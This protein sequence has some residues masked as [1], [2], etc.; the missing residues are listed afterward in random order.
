MKKLRRYGLIGLFVI[1]LAGLLGIPALQPAAAQQRT[2]SLYVFPTQGAPGAEIYLKGYGLTADAAVDVTLYSL[3]PLQAFTVGT[4]TAG[5]DGEFTFTGV[6]PVM[7]AGPASIEAVYSGGSVSADFTVLPA[8][9]LSLG[10]ISG[11][12]GQTVSFSVDSLLPG[13]LRLDYDGAPI[14]GPVSVSDPIFNG[15]FIVPHDRPA[16]LG[17]RVNVEAVNLV[18]GRVVGRIRDGFQSQPAPG[19]GGYTFDRIDLPTQAVDPGQVFTI[20]G[21]FSPPPSFPLSNYQLKVLYKDPGGQILP[22]THGLAALLADGSFTVDAKMPSFF[23]GDAVAVSE[24]AQI[25]IALFAQDPT[26]SVIN[27]WVPGAGLIHVPTPPRFRIQVKDTQGHPI[28]N[29]VVQFN[30]NLPQMLANQP[31]GGQVSLNGSELKGG[32]NQVL[33]FGGGVLFNDE[34]DPYTCAAT[35]LYGK[36]DANGYFEPALNWDW[37][38]LAGSKILQGYLGQGSYYQVPLEITFSF[39]V[40]A[41]HQGFGEVDA[42]GHPVLREETILYKVTTN[43]YYNP[44]SSQVINA[45]DPYPVVL[46]ALPPA[47]SVGVPLKLSIPG[48]LVV[49]Y[50]DN[51]VGTG[52]PMIAYGKYV[53]FANTSEFPNAIIPG[54]LNLKVE[55]NNDPLLYGTL[56]LNTLTATLDGAL[57]NPGFYLSSQKGN[58]TGERYTLDLNAVHRWSV[59]SHTLLVQVKDLAGNISKH[60]LVIVMVP[61]PD[62]FRNA[63]LQDRLALFWG[64]GKVELRANYLSPS[65]PNTSSTLSANVP[66]IGVLNNMAGTNGSLNQIFLLSGAGDKQFKTILPYQALNNSGSKT[67]GA[68]ATAPVPITYSNT[69]PILDTGRVPLYRHVFGAP[70]IAGAVL[71]ADMWFKATLTYSGT[72]KIS[73]SAGTSDVHTAITPTAKVGVDA[74]VDASALFGL[75]DA[76]AHAIPNIGLSLPVEYQN[77]QKIDAKKCFQYKLDIS[78]S[79]SIGYCPLCVSA[80]GTENLFDGQTPSSC[81]LPAA[82]APLAPAVGPPPSSSPAIANDGAGHTLAVW[83]A[84]NGTILSSHNTGAGWETALVVS[85]NTSSGSP[86][87]AFYAPNRALAL[88]TQSAL[89]PAQAASATFAALVNSQRLAYAVWNGA[90]W[91]SAQLL[92]TGTATG[93]G[94]PALAACLSTTAGCPAGGAVAAAWV[95]DAA[96]DLSQHQYRIYTA[97]YAN[98]GWGTVQ[99]VDPASTAADAQPT[100]VYSG[101]SPVVLWVRD[102]DRDFGTL[103]DRRVAYRDLGGGGV[104]AP[105][106]LPYGVMEP[107]LAAD[108]SG[109]LRLAF[110]LGT[111]TGGLLGNQRQLYSARRTCSGA[112]TWAVQALADGHGRPVRAEGPVLTVDALG[113]GTIT[114]R[115]L[116]FGPLPGGSVQSFPEDTQG[117]ITGTGDLAQIEVNFSSAL[118]TPHY[119]TNDTGVEWQAA[120]TFDPL[121]KQNIVLA[122]QGPLAVTDARYVP[123]AVASA[124]AGAAL[125]DQPLVSGSL[126][127]LPDFTPV[128]A[129]VSNHYPQPRDAVSV[130]VEIRNDGA[131]VTL[132]DPLLVQVAWDGEPGIGAL[133]GELT[134]TAP[135][136]G[137]SVVVA[138]PLDTSPVNLELSHRLHITVNPAGDLPE[139]DLGNNGILAGIGGL[140]PPQDVHASARTGSSL[141]FLDWTAVTD[142]RV[143][144][145]RIYRSQ[146]GGSLEPVGTTFVNGFA[147]L[148]AAM[149]RAYDYAV[150]SFSVDG[151]EGGF[152]DLVPASL[153][154]YRILLPVIQHAR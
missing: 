11:A 5:S 80:G 10:A 40:N 24:N 27:N 32:P 148:T 133:A 79:V 33:A 3:S 14:F 7:P 83:R 36:T 136:P 61:P 139:T 150:V 130:Q 99:A 106:D 37:V 107:S 151:V 76:N 49:S 115:A 110:T 78:W 43:Q 126:L 16:V 149:D 154:S 9:V 23:N 117:V 51:Y 50:F 66:K 103:A 112:C 73:A 108:P 74:F 143:A 19:V 87:V 140:P 12:P 54:G 45:T 26:N 145:Y 67:E 131:P 57:L 138:I 85:A 77:G 114:Y 129:E 102:S 105:S 153:A 63:S 55:F 21:K 42:Q 64:N 132:A 128:S 81:T 71:G 17:V 22:I 18:D 96:G 46:P 82:D 113:Q 65:D 88:W 38:A 28:P 95:R 89:T 13:Q 109:E 4:G 116:G 97:V 60:Y 62:W 25:G 44:T 122:A 39:K 68:T 30:N 48:G 152:Q 84:A 111:D 52:A 70:P 135:A 2:A 98:A 146:P 119:L 69:I 137:E 47:T 35:D 20:A 1:F 125:P 91:S 134:L 142:P 59:G 34:S 8:L 56:D 121:V 6:V 41:W 127:R 144:G 75:V 147:D 53:S 101:G 58:C 29:A 124:V 100:L 104:V 118:F 94:K 92:A 141:L 120:A 123:D 86:R 72:I 90:A 15:A 93:E 31:D